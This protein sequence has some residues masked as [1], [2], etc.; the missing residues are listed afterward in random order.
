MHIAL[1]TP[2]GKS[3]EIQA[4]SRPQKEEEMDGCRLTRKEA[5]K[6]RTIM[7]CFM[8]PK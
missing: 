5:G 3:R 6:P 1:G 8:L 7:S 2:L 4:Q